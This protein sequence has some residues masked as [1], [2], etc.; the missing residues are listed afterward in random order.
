MAGKP[1]AV[2]IDAAA[3]AVVITRSVTIAPLLIHRHREGLA[4]AVIPDA[5]VASDR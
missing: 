3:I 5:D 2:C 1:I 4:G